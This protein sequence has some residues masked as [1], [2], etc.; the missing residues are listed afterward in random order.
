[1]QQKVPDMLIRVILVIWWREVAQ[2]RRMMIFG[3][4][5]VQDASISNVILG[6]GTLLNTKRVCVEDSDDWTL[7][8]VEDEMDES[9]IEIF[10]YPGVM[11]KIQQNVILHD[12]MECVEYDWCAIYCP[13]RVLSP[14]K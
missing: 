3:H 14:Q 4:N 5:G 13:Q 12:L 11:A 1:M 8:S 10:R 6:F 9:F 2:I 7:L